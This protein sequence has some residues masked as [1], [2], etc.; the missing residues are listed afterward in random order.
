MCEKA[1]KGRRVLNLQPE[2]RNLQSLFQNGRRKKKCSD[3]Q[4]SRQ[5]FFSIASVFLTWEL[6]MAGPPFFTDDPVPVPYHH[7][8]FYSFSTMDKAAGGSTVQLPAFEFNVGA[9]P[10]LQIHFVGPLVRANPNGG[11]AA[12]G[13]GDLELGAKYCFVNEKGIR[14]QIGI[15]PMLE[16][17]SGNAGRGL[18]NGTLWARLPVWLQKSSGPWTTYGGAGYKL[19][20]A[21]AMRDSVFTG[22]LLQRDFGGRLTLGGEFYMQTA[23]TVAGRSSSYF[24]AGG[25]YYFNPNFQLLFM[26]GH[27]IAGENHTVGYWGLYWTW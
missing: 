24:N 12:Y 10:N 15:F 9:A 23:Q 2:I 27:T 18:G 19:N 5:I 26:L 7:Y 20:Q 22:W 25:Y 4:I 16:I 8:E 17:P 6:L 3:R 1:T 11:N 21:P 13:L 14:P